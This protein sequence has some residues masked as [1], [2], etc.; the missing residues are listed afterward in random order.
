MHP[1]AP[2]YPTFE[3]YPGHIIIQ[4]EERQLLAIFPNS[5]VEEGKKL[6]SLYLP[7]YYPQFNICKQ[8]LFFGESRLFMISIDPPVYPYNLT[9]IYPAQS[10]NPTMSIDATFVYPYFDICKFVG[11]LY[12]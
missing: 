5:E 12:S 10:I 2:V 8:F 1:D 11:S 6:T 7:R 3:L 4:Q 9:T